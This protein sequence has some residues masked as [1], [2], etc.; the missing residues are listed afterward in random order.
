MVYRIEVVVV[1][2]ELCEK[3]RHSGGFIAARKWGIE[4]GN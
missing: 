1:M 4:T 3:G 2:E